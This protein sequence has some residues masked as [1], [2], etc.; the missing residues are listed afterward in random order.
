MNLEKELHPIGHYIEDRAE[1]LRQ[2]RPGFISLETLGQN[3]R[4]SSRSRDQ[5]AEIMNKISEMMF[6]VPNDSCCKYE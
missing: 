5:V 4:G 3:H 1:M 6:F 2:V